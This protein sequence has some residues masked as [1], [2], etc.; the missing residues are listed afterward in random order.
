MQPSKEANARSTLPF[1]SLRVFEV[2]GR[3]GSFTK[4][5]EELA[6]TTGAVSQHVRILES[7]ARRLLFVRRGRGVELTEIGRLALSEA[8]MA[9]HH[10][11]RAGAILRAGSPVSCARPP[12]PLPETGEH[13]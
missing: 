12:V 10:A 8:A 4:A 5:A 13:P 7:H 6:I 1:A 9:L 2:A 3:L 11:E